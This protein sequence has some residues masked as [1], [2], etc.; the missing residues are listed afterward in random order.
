MS[1]SIV[2]KGIYEHLDCLLT[3]I[4]RL[5]HAGYS[6]FDV[7][8]PLPRHEIEE[9]IYEGRPSPVRWWTLAGAVTGVTGGFVLAALTAAEWPMANPGGKPTVSLP[10]FIIIM[11]ESTILLGGLATMAGFVVH[12]GL[13]SLWLNKALQDPRCTDASF[14]I[15]FTH[16]E[17][18]KEAEIKQIL[19]SS[20]AIEVTSGAEAVYEVP[21]G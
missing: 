21:N 16:A 8:A 19:N 20:G 9:M 15:V 2:V 6:G 5:K 1:N 3:G 7:M 12:A 11:F 4:E 14:G 17:P 18:D 13:P 10:P